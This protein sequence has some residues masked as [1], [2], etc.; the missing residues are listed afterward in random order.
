MKTCL[1]V[2]RWSRA[3]GPPLVPGV[4]RGPTLYQCLLV[5][6]LFVGLVW[7]V[8]TIQCLWALSPLLRALC[9]LPPA[10]HGDG[11]AIRPVLLAQQFSLFITASSLS[12]QISLI[13]LSSTVS[14]LSP[15]P[16]AT[17]LTLCLNT[18]L[19]VPLFASS[20]HNFYLF[21]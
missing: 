4:P 7:L 5:V 10:P 15:Q 18:V 20:D 17:Q 1:E 3:S 21:W 2:P 8:P 13:S 11:G 16:S 12:A 6:L 14:V 19:R 9:L